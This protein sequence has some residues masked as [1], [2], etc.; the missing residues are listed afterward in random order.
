MLVWVLKAVELS[1]KV[2]IFIDKEVPAAADDTFDS[3]RLGV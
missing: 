2:S 1:L 3:K